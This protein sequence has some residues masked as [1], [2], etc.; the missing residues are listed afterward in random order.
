MQLEEIIENTKQLEFINRLNNLN[1]ELLYSQNSGYT[2]LKSKEAMKS[3]KDIISKFDYE[4][5]KIAKDYDFKNIDLIINDKRKEIINQ[6]KKHYE[7]ETLN[8]TKSVFDDMRE[9][10]FLSASTTASFELRLI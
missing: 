2:T 3:A 6:I 9:N 7:E 10:S 5:S 1:F 8:W 4:S